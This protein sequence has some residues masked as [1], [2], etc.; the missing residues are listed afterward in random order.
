MGKIY[1]TEN[2]E[3][4]YIIQVPFLT[5]PAICYIN[6]ISD[7]GTWEHHLTLKWKY[8]NWF[9]KIKQS[10]YFS[11]LVVLEDFH[12]I[13]WALQGV[14]PIL[15]IEIVDT[16]RG[17]GSG[18]SLVAMGNGWGNVFVTER[19]IKRLKTLK[20]VVKVKVKAT[21]L[22]ITVSLVWHILNSKFYILR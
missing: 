17:N 16:R 7:I 4:N 8:L 10:S 3:V 20:I 22:P 21:L 12:G 5:K 2:S 11:R 14:V 1:I 18:W 9:N 19:K 15:Q 13:F 6:R